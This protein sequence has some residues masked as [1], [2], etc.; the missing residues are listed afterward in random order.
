MLDAANLTGKQLWCFTA[1]ASLPISVIE[2]LEIPIDR[3]QKGLPIL[4]HN[5]QDYG[6][7]FEDKALSKTYKVFVPNKTGEK[8]SMCE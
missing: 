1:P 8:Y 4:S 5:D 2:N 7:T 6:V 3:A